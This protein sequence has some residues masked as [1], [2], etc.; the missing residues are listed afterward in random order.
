MVERG[1]GDNWGSGKRSEREGM[2]VLRNIKRE[3]RRG[4]EAE[5]YGEKI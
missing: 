1:V 2:R 3:K 5:D 4:R